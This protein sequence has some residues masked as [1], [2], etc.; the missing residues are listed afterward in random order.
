MKTI[1]RVNQLHGNVKTLHKDFFSKNKRRAGFA[2]DRI[3]KG[4]CF[5]VKE[6]L[7]NLGLM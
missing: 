4:K 2:H 7:I 6:T 1:T 3:R 5:V